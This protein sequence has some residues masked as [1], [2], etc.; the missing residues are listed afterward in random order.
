M[1][2]SSDVATPLRATTTAL[3][4]LALSLIRS[5]ALAAPRWVDRP[6]TLPRL[7]FAGDVGIGLGRQDFPNPAGDAVGPG[8]NVEGALGVTDNV[9][10]GLRTGF[11]L[12]DD[13]RAVG[14]DGYGRTLWT[15][16]WG[17]NGST[18]ANPEFR[19]RWSVYSG[20][21]AEVA[22]DGRMFMP[23]EQNSRF[24]LMFGVPLAFHLGS[25]VRIDTGGYIP[26]VFD[27]RLNGLTIPGYFWFQ[28]SDRFWL[29][30]MTS[31]RFLD[32]G[33]GDHDASLLVG[34]GFGYQVANAF[35]LKWQAFLPDVTRNGAFDTF[36]AGFGIQFRIE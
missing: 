24:G 30:P 10:L 29:G 19:V 26:V 32:Y 14:A 6:I 4:A 2:A 15:E 3:G 28:T 22:L 1:R 17:T 13:A 23:V 34:M 11:R 33:P 25:I 31:L 9:E 36:G 12:T 20:R 35:D 21:I 16:T 7:V 8:L 18:V 27:S 5:D